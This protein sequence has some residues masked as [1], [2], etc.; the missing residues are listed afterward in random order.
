MHRTRKL[1]FLGDAEAA[2]RHLAKP[3]IPKLAGRF[4]FVPHFLPT[5][6][7][8]GGILLY[9][10]FIISVRI[11]SIYFHIYLFLPNDFATQIST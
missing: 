2:I 10:G 3:I 5:H 11:A 6:L 8:T 7:L 9:G 1:V 4:N